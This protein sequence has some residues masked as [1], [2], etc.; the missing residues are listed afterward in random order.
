MSISNYLSEVSKDDEL[1]LTAEQC[2]AALEAGDTDLLFDSC[3]KLVPYI[4]YYHIGDYGELDFDDLIQQGNEAALK[5]IQ[6]Y[7]AGHDNMVSS[8]AYRYIK[9]YVIR[10][11]VRQRTERKR[12][13]SMDYFEEDDELTLDE[14]T[15]HTMSA[16]SDE[17]SWQERVENEIDTVN[18][19]KRLPRD[20]RIILQLHLLGDSQ[21]SIANKFNLT[22][23][24]VSKRINDILAS[25]T[26]IYQE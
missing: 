21:A 13:V 16:F 22:Q 2:E 20:D 9:S 11:A 8:W 14:L 19:L 24:S 4:V 18:I 10:E 5:A 12:L 7:K 17:W 25:L 15:E 1:R 3:K 26:A 6:S 23:G